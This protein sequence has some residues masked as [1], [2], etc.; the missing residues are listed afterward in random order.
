MNM[1]KIYHAEF[2]KNFKKAKRVIKCLFLD[3][4]LTQINVI[5]G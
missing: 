2:S 4:I 3:I 1:I 5:F